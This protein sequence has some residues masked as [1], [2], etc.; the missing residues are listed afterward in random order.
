MNELERRRIMIAAANAKNRPIYVLNE[1]YPIAVENTSYVY[2]NTTPVNSD[3]IVVITWSQNYIITSTNNRIFLYANDE[4]P[5]DGWTIGWHMVYNKLAFWTD[6]NYEKWVNLESFTKCA[7]KVEGNNLYVTKDGL[8]WISFLNVEDMSKA[9][10]FGWGR[11]FI[12]SIHA[13]F[14]NDI[15]TDVSQ[16]FK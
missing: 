1:N 4:S 6:T 15:T 9:K 3:F 11:D 2:R 7:I 12:G 16:F 10:R 14:Y 5:W 13:D 8:N